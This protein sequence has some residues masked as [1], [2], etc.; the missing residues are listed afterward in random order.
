MLEAWSVGRGAHWR[1]GD[2]SPELSLMT[3][4]LCHRRGRRYG[5]RG[6]K[7]EAWSDAQRHGDDACVIERARGG[8]F[9]LGKLVGGETDGGGESSWSLLTLWG[10]CGRTKGTGRSAR[11]WGVCDLGR[12]GEGRCLLARIRWRS[13]SEKWRCQGNSGQPSGSGRVGSEGKGRGVAGD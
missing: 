4:T 7:R 8:W 1:E 9:L 6:N 5:S 13:S 10:E 11:G 3:A 12:G 2:C